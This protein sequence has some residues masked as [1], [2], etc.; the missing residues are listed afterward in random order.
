ML[1]I[2]CA[3]AG[4]AQSSPWRANNEVIPARPDLDVLWKNSAKFPRKVWVYQLLPNHFSPEIISNLMALCSFT[5]K[6]KIDDETNG[7]MFQ[8]TDHS[9]TLSIS[10][11]SGAI[12]YETAEIRYSPTN[13]AVGVPSTNELPEVAKSVLSK[14]HIKFSDITGWLG[15]NKIDFS[16]PVTTFY[17][18][19]AVITN[20]PYRTVYFRR[21]VDGMPI[22]YD[23]YR[24]NFGE[25]GRISKISI[26][27]PNLKRVKSYRT[28]SPK[29]VVNFIRDG[30][31]TRGPV[32]TSIG[33]IDWPSIKSLTI[34]DAIP[35]YLVNGNR[36]YPFLYLG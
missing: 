27:W 25:H 16:E 32:P 3:T 13:L 29:D 26:A 35:S 11:S 7:L 30:N 34:T 19:D 23:F 15:T 5:G 28:V 33:D 12:E 18:G 20:V 21:S 9:R 22:A 1:Q 6:D 31:A 10:Y 24:L 2:V 17:V 8:S 4:L 14:L 36:L